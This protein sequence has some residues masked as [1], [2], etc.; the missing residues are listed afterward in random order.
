LEKKFFTMDEQ[1]ARDNALT[2]IA[3]GHAANS[4]RL[5]HKNQTSRSRTLGRNMISEGP[6]K[7][8]I[9]LPMQLMRLTPLQER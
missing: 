3:L 5:Q 1:T 8:L 6:Q 9:N 7:V 2:R 4:T